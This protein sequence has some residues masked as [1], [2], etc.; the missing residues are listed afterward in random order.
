M[1]GQHSCYHPLA[2]CF[3]N[4]DQLIL[5]GIILTVGS[6]IQSAAGFAFG[7]FAIPLLMLSGFE[8]FEAIA[9]VGMC[10]WVQSGIGA[11]KLRHFADWQSLRSLTIFVILMQPVG[12]YLQGMF[13]E[14][15]PNVI[16][17][18]FGGMLLVVVISQVLF[19]PR[20]REAVGFGWSALAMS[21]SGL[22]GGLTGTSGPPVVLWAMAH[23]WPSQRTR[24][25]MFAMFFIIIPLNMIFQTLTFGVEVLESAAIGL[26][27]TPV[28][29]LG[30]IP[31]L[32]I[33]S[34]LTQRALRRVAF[35]LLFVI[36]VYMLVK[37]MVD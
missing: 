24:A 35:A 26:A 12:A 37:P 17:Q 4:L 21:C 28:V 36:A 23:D 32:W 18:V 7:L 29:W 3:M 13:N 20:P 31:G 2:F 8:S 11:W 19:R 16:K 34:L 27:Y 33:G 10:A 9:I 25:T 22:L 5:I 6:A 1:M 15:G 14:Q 30:T